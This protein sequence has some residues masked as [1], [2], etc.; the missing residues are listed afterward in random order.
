MIRL[1]ITSAAFEAIADTIPQSVSMEAQRAPNGGY[2][3]WLD[4]RYVDRLRAMRGPIPMSFCGWRRR[5]GPV[6]GSS[7]SV[8]GLVVFT[9]WIV[10]DFASTIPNLKP[11]VF[12]FPFFEERLAFVDRL[13]VRF[14]FK[15][16]YGGDVPASH[17][18]A[19]HAFTP[20][21][22][23]ECAFSLIRR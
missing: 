19:A 10:S 8:S 9:R 4:P 14:D 12:R 5:N 11:I 3:I 21:L 7:L 23:W 18:V 1:T 20:C 2:F 13:L 22:P 6:L 15:Q 16:L 17:E